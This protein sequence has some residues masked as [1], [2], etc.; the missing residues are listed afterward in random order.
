MDT[1]VRPGDN[2]YEYTNGK[3]LKSTTIPPDRPSVNVFSELAQQTTHQV[4][5]LIQ[6]LARSDAKQEGEAKFHNIADLYDSYMDEAT[7]DRKGLN[8]LKAPLARIEQLHD[9][10]GLARLLGEDLRADVDPLNNTNYHTPNL[11]GIWVAPGFHDSSHYIIYLLQGGLEMPDR[12][13]YIDDT[14]HMRT[15]R[16]QYRSHV[17]QMLKLAG[18]SE[19]EARADRVLDLEHQI[20]E[21]HW[22]LADDQ[23]IHKA[24]NL[25][26]LSEF[27]AKAPGLDW[28]EFFRAAGLS[29]Q[30]VMNVWQPSA[31]SGEAGLVNSAPLQQWKDWLTYHAIEDHAEALPKALDAEHFEFFGHVLSG[32]PQQRPRWQRAVF[33][34]DDLLG[35]EVGQLYAKKYFPPEAK[36]RAQAM[37]QNIVAAFHKRIDAVPWMDPKTKAQANAKLDALYVGIG[38]P[39]SW[40]DYSGLEIQRDDLF[41]NEVRSSLFEYRRQISR[42]GKTVDRHEWCMTPQTVNAVNLPLQNALNFPAAILQPPFF[43]P[44]AP[45]AVNYG[46]IGSII[47]HEISHTFDSE[48]S[49]FDATGELRNWWTAEDLQHFEAATQA[50]AKQYDSYHPFADLALRGEQT[51]AEN[52]ADLGGLAAAYDAYRASLHGK[53]AP[54]QGGFTG[55]QQYFI[56]YGQSRRSKARE[57]ALRRQ[58]LT[59]EHAPFE[60]RTDTVRN[61]DAWYDAFQVK[62]GEKLYLA[63]QER[64]RIW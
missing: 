58:V 23:D 5:A 46:A 42:L 14:E 3:W 8:P 50:L 49:T 45:D 1:S 43:D 59:D 52:I 27:A 35:D 13:Y 16:G 41:G 38:Y 55:D 62:P 39:E 54:E 2:F 11:F 36:A 18:I 34:V 19:P 56:G 64:V 48:G 47:G 24:D 17:I 31:I 53:E 60:Y 63:P 61:V 32:V 12:A 7:I 37:V 44:Q 15:I 29:S 25:W 20:A 40:R 21:K 30:R 28:Q 22:S 9:K 26:N 33:E 6:S 57:A 4:S 51:L 10:K